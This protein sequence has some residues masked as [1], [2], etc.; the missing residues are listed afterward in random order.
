MKSTCLSLHSEYDFLNCVQKSEC[1]KNLFS[2]VGERQLQSYPFYI[3]FKYKGPQWLARIE[4]N[5]LELLKRISV[6]KREILKRKIK[7]LA[8]LQNNEGLYAGVLFEILLLGPLASHDY[9]NEYEPEISKGNK[10]DARIRIQEFCFNLEATVDLKGWR[11]KLPGAISAEDFLDS[12][13]QKIKTKIKQARTSQYPLLIAMSQPPGPGLWDF[14]PFVNKFQNFLFT[15]PKV[16]GVIVAKDCFL[17]SNRL[18]INNS[19]EVSQNVWGE[20]RRIYH[21]V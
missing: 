19:C 2:S 14:C 15:F 1:L 16:M 20:L 13:F 12:L 21:F 7:D 6:N 3:D 4:N 9:L 8:V 5:I 10:C 17:E 18:F 11:E